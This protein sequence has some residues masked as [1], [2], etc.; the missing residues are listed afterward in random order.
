MAGQ[1]LDSR[2]REAMAAFMASHPRGRYGAVDYDLAQL[3]LDGA[4]RRRALR[5]YSDRF[6]ITLES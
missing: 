3:G 5:F 2:A 6:G 1:P 4:E